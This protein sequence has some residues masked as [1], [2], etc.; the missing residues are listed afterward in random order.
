MEKFPLGHGPS[1]ALGE[2][3][4][5]PEHALSAS[6]LT[7]HKHDGLTGLGEKFKYRIVSQAGK[8]TMGNHIVGHK[9]GAP[10]KDY[11]DANFQGARHRHYF[12]TDRT[13]DLDGKTPL[14]ASAEKDNNMPPYLV[15]N[16]I[17]KADGPPKT[18][19]GGGLK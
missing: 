1:R 13:L 3:K 4:G 9:S 5:K 2:A 14:S 11:D 8:E 7:A 12:M 10:S 15:I 17:I 16:Y 18:Q 19:A 6:E